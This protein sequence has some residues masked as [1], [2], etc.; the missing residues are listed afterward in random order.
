M[1]QGAVFP[2]PVGVFLKTPA[3][4]VAPG[5]LPHTRGGVSEISDV[6]DDLRSVFPT[7]VGV[8]LCVM[9]VLA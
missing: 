5:R 2:T 6:C 9:F 4:L 3:V 1:G 8:F 7:P